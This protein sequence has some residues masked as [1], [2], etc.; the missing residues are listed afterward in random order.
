MNIN[1]L[2]WLRDIIE[3]LEQKHSVKQQEVEEI[4][5]S[6]P[7]IRYAEKGHRS[8]E[9]AYAAFGQTKAGRFSVVYF[10][11]KKDGRALIISARDMTRTE[12]RR[13]EQ[14]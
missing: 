12:R 3:K 1:G 9:D 7:H 6:K 10:V 4:F 13:Y 14:R 11:Y 2:M 8:G 5:A